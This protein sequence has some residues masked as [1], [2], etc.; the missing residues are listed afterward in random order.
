MSLRRE[1]G[2]RWGTANGLNNLGQIARE[3]G[4]L[5]TAQAMFEES[6]A[7]NRE[8]GDKGAI[9]YL[10]ED[11]GFLAARQHEPQRA[12]TLL[13]LQL[14]TSALVAAQYRWDF[15]ADA[16]ISTLWTAT[17]IVPLLVVYGGENATACRGGA[18]VSRCWGRAGSSCCRAS[19]TARSSSGRRTSS[20]RRRPHA[21][22]AGPASGLHPGVHRD[23]HH[24][25]RPDPGGPDA[26]RPVHADWS[27]VAVDADSS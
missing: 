10:L 7:I 16:L 9:V 23:V 4:D 27:R 2:D 1:I 24:S 21:L 20:R 6:L 3:I 22:P 15:V 19:S 13:A 18:S 26:A 11:F 12:L 17:A 14:R 8:I 25:L 5:T